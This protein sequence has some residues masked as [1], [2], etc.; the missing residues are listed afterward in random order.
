MASSAVCIF[1]SDDPA[2]AVA[3]KALRVNLSDLAA[4]GSAR[5]DFC[6]RSRCRRRLASLA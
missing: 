5:L 2:D 4:K 3:K 1:F 6:S